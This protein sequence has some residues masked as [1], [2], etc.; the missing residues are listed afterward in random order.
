MVHV[1]DNWNFDY[2]IPKKVGIVTFYLDRGKQRKGKWIVHDL[3][4][5]E[6]KVHLL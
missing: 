3:K 2:V 4:E 6:T 1:G 5:F